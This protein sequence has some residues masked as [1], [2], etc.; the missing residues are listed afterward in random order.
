MRDESNLRFRSLLRPL[1]DTANG[2]PA[3]VIEAFGDTDG[4]DAKGCHDAA[5][6]MIIS[7]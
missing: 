6:W 5:G 3:I 2:N 7:Q 1:M 4:S